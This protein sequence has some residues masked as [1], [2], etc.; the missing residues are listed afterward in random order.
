MQ[1]YI[2]L[3]VLG[4]KAYHLPNSGCCYSSRHGQFT[5][6]PV[7]VGSLSTNREQKYGQ[8]FSQYLADPQ[9][10]F[11]ISSDF[12]HWGTYPVKVTKSQSV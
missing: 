9:N 2:Q 5:I 7:M 4:H 8:I 6:V 11:V 12:C 1:P 3:L 10:L